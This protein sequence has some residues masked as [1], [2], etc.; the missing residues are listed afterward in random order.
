MDFEALII[1]YV[2]SLLAFFF[3]LSFFAK[4]YNKCASLRFLLAVW[5]CFICIPC[6]SS[7][8]KKAERASRM[9]EA[10]KQLQAYMTTPLVDPPVHPSL[11]TVAFSF[12]STQLYCEFLVVYLLS[13]MQGMKFDLNSHFQLDKL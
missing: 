12:P 3:F 10:S 2:W 6:I 11:F 7:P 8:S 9:S 1:Y 4:Q 5:N 13:Q